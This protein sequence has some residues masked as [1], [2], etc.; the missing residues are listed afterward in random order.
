[1]AVPSLE[2]R[3]SL[4]GLERPVEVVRD[5][6]GI[7][8]I[9]AESLHDAFF[10]Q[11]FAHAQDRLWQMEYDR[12]RA[13]GRWAEYAGPSGVDQDV[14]MRRLGLVASA[15][16]DYAAVNAETRAMLDAYAAGVN[17]FISTTDALPIEYRLVGGEPEQ[18]EPWQSGAVFKVRHILMGSLAVKLWRLRVLK[19]LGPEW[20]GRLRAGSGAESPLV[21]PPGV[22]YADV[23]DGLGE[24][25]TL[26]EL[27]HG[28]GDV[29]GG[30]NNWVVHGRRTATGKPLLAGDPHRAL[31]VPNV[32]YQNH[33]ACPELD[34]IG[35]SF[36]GVPG[37]P[38]FGHNRWVA[39]GV[40]HATADYQDLY[41]ERF[42]PGD[43]ARYDFKGEWRAA[44][45]R[46]E[47][48]RVRG[49]TPVEIGVTVTHHGPIVLGDPAGGYA[50]ALRY[51]ATA[52]PN[53]S[54]EALLSMPRARTVAELDET[55]RPWVDP[56]N[57]FVMADTV[58]TIGY[59]TR[60]QVPVRARANGWLPVPGWTGEHEW[61]GMVP[62]EEMPRARDPE[63]G[64]I[65]TANQRI[66]GPDYPH[67]ISLDW[68]TPHRAQ[69]VNDR[70][71]ALTA[72]GPA[73]MA[74]IHADK[75]SI[76]SR[77]MVALAREVEP[78]DD[79]SAE[80]IRRLLAWDGTMGPSDPAATIYAAW[81]EQITALVLAGPTFAP[82][83]RA[84]GRWDPPPAQPQP[85][86]Q[87]LRNPLYGLLA[88]RD[89]AA[90]PPGETWPT[91]GAK[92]LARACD[93]LAQ[94]LG[95]DP[96]NWRWELVHRTRPCHTLSAAFPEL[97]ELLD[98]PAVGVGGDSDTPQ[99]GTFGG[100]DPRDFTITSTA[101]AR[102]CFDLSDWDASGWTVPH[103][104]SG[105]PGSPHYADQAPAWTEQRLAP[106]LYSWDRVVADAEARQRLEPAPTGP[107]RRGNR[108]AD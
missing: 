24:S 17:A 16:A 106:M 33:L 100:A 63:Q 46:S 58:G 40:T 26:A 82:L 90:L 50:L 1:M 30:S 96:D 43:P 35:F 92:A 99:N 52:E 64:F 44:E 29:D 60:G 45:R 59:L 14:L 2:G 47:T 72:A 37:F 7:P 93:W 21:V 77:A 75:R 76:P 74:A 11:G 73:D 98:P 5:S 89:P 88:R 97:A 105:H 78:L 20:I 42:A 13:A 4:A 3:V 38:H 9:R 61:R 41:V 94:R 32:Y 84:A 108:E 91:L 54:F 56:G 71:R 69:R 66:V 68:G 34:A 53:R 22:S 107:P 36:V 80:A 85:A 15:R 87:R 23:P 49:A 51:T 57:N 102:Y 86:A 18:W 83:A 6:L 31:D 79:R 81:R 39:W 62:F 55:M 67:Y 101:V 12:R 19:T 8:H 95:P 27:M 103:G 104:S 48:I 65:A 70:L 10:A 25:R 28:L